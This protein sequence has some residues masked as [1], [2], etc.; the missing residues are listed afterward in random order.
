MSRFQQ[1]L[2]VLSSCQKDIALCVY[3]RVPER[4]ESFGRKIASQESETPATTSSKYRIL[5]SKRKNVCV[6]Y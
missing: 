6:Q 5:L 2:L 4:I 1:E 3:Q